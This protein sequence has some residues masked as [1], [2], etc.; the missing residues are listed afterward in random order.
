MGRL[1]PPPVGEYDVVV[2]GSGPG[3]LQ[4]AY[5]L[6]RLGVRHAVLSA[7]DGPGGMFRDWP[8][9]QRLLSRSKPSAP[10]PVE[11]RAYERYDLVAIPTA[12]DPLDGSVEDLRP[13]A[14]GLVLERLKVA[15]V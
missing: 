11:T 6:S 14:D 12:L 10:Y 8:I 4:T 5:H 7:D 13:A 2:V 3:G 15:R 9:F 1:A